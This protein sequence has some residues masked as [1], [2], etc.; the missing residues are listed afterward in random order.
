MLFP[1]TAIICSILQISKHTLSFPMVYRILFSIK[2]HLINQFSPAP[3]YARFH[4]EI[5]N[6]LRQ[7]SIMRLAWRILLI[8]CEKLWLNNVESKIFRLPL[9]S[10]EIWLT[11]MCCKASAMNKVRLFLTTHP[12]KVSSR[13]GTFKEATGPFSRFNKIAEKFLIWIPKNWIYK[14]GRSLESKCVDKKRANFTWR[15]IIVVG[16]RNCKI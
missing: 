2:T 3:S 16:G 1:Y 9:C 8:V 5:N 4:W 14:K 6:Y 13:L 12:S 10:N 15:R 11:L 7:T